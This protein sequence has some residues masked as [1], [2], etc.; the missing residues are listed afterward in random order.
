MK[1][2]INKTN[3]KTKRMYITHVR[4]FLRYNYTKPQ[5]SIKK[6]LV[7][8]EN[9]VCSAIMKEENIDWSGITN[10]TIKLRRDYPEFIADAQQYIGETIEVDVPVDMTPREYRIWFCTL[11]FDGERYQGCD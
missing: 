2:E 9:M 6:S 3:K 1:I 4:K 5:I 11:T 8:A 7:A 10:F